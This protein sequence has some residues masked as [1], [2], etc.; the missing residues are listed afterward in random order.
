LRLGESV[1]HLQHL[2]LGVPFSRFFD[3]RSV[4]FVHKLVRS[5]QPGY[6][7]DKIRVSSNQPLRLIPSRNRTS[8]Y[9]SSFFVRGV[10][11]YNALPVEIRRT[12]TVAGFVRLC[13]DF[14]AL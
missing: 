12:E 8:S 6:L 10:L 14:Y 4:V 13:K 1:T 9:N 7:H 11:S 5:R 3:F 2:L